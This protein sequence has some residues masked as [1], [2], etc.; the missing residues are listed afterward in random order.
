MRLQFF[1][2]ARTRQET[3]T[4]RDRG[5]SMVEFALVVPIMFV[6]VVAI[7]DFGRVF[8][9][10]SATESAAREAADYGAFLGSAKWAS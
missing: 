7:A 1:K 2:R 5:Q 6:M 8:G 4:S 3:R 9:A 10:L